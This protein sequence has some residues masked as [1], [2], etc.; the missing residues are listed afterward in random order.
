MPHYPR[1]IPPLTEPS[2][3]PRQDHPAVDHATKD[4]SV[5]PDRPFPPASPPKPGFSSGSD[6]TASEFRPKD[7]EAIGDPRA[8]RGIAA[9]NIDSAATAEPMDRPGIIRDN[10]KH[11]K[12]SVRRGRVRRNR[13]ASRRGN[14]FLRAWMP[15]FFE[16]LPAKMSAR[17]NQSRHHLQFRPPLNFRHQAEIKPGQASSTPKAWPPFIHRPLRRTGKARRNP[18][19]RS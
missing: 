7:S 1:E 11:A 5:R 12:Q 19:R 17:R 14:P 15:A 13:S 10:P 4:S 2:G 3:A 18:A 16:S 9:K 6:Q 8:S